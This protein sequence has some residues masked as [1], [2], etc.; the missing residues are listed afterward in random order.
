[1]EISIPSLLRIKPQAVDK[2]GKY[3]S[4][5]GFKRIALF[6][7]QGIRELVGGRIDASLAAHGVAVL[8]GDT[9]GDNDIGKV[10]ATTLA[11]PGAVQAVVAVGGGLVVD[12]SKYAAFVAQLPIVTVP[13]AISNDG[14]ASPGASLLV[15]G[16]R[17]SMKARIPYGVILD[18]ELIRNSPRRLSLSG[19]GDLLS[20]YTAER[21]WKLS[22]HRTGEAVND[23]AVLVSR[24]S[25]D[26]V[27]NWPHQDPGRLDYIQL[28]C[29]AL[30]MS[31]VA[32]E[33]SASSR[34][35]SGSEHLISHAYDRY[36][37][38]PTLH[39]LQVGVATLAVA[40]LQENPALPTIRRVLRESGF[41]DLLRAEPLSRADFELAVDRSGE[42]KPGYYTCLSEP[43]AGE[44]LKELCRADSDLADFLR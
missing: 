34:P 13:T 40:L 15:D 31:G 6:Y 4:G 23:F 44:R 27:A 29:G 32:M 18:T 17:R 10:F 36:A 14:F 9:I 3:V 35:A 33:I 28:V 24:Q 37:A 5:A 11:I 8:H 41:A 25:V 7:G 43:G 30:V 22:F 39:G 1:M 21:D 19:I 38:K 12:Y 26:S 42:I 16:R 20:K 2:L